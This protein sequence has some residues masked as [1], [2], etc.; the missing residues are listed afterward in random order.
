MKIAICLSGQH[1]PEYINFD[2]LSKF[3]GYSEADIFIHQWADSADQK[4]ID[5]FKPKSFVF[6]S[7]RDFSYDAKKFLSAFVDVDKNYYNSYLGNS[8]RWTR[9]NCEL[10]PG[11]VF[12]NDGNS[13]ELWRWG[14][15]ENDDKTKKNIEHWW[16]KYASQL[17]SIYYSNELRKMYERIHN[18]EYNFVIRF[19]L[20][21]HIEKPIDLRLLSNHELHTV[22][23]SKYTPE[24]INF[25]G[26]NDMLAIASGKNMDAYC[27]TYS[28]LQHAL[29]NVHDNPLCNR[30]TPESLILQNLLTQNIKINQIHSTEICL[31]R[32]LK[33]T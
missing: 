21:V 12:G 8:W 25:F 9:K 11:M 32:R 18:F 6:E 4:I 10:A 28:H 26:I 23:Q 7:Q 5:H 19:R 13:N 15:V 33:S 16:Y 2:F 17:Y 22:Y 27:S 24:R 3:I 14:M 20:D 1:R 31:M 29:K 30:L